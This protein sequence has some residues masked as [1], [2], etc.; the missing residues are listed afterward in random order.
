M[1][2]SGAPP[3]GEGGVSA[4]LVAF[5]LGTA[6]IVLCRLLLP[7]LL[8]NPNWAVWIS[9]L[10]AVAAI[11]TLGV[12][13]H[14][15]RR[16]GDI[17]R[18][19]DDLYY[20]GLLFTL[21]SLIYALVVLFLID[22]ADANLADRT[23]ELI[24]SFGIA[25]LSTVAGILGRI[26]LQGT[27]NGEQRSSGGESGFDARAPWSPAPRSP[28]A[29][30]RR[31]DLELARLA[32]RLRAELRGASDAFSHY[33]RMTL[34]Q[35]EDTKRHAQRVVEEFTRELRENARSAIVESESAYRKLGDQIHATGGELV[36]RVEQVTG[37]LAPL[38]ETV[39]SATHAAAGFPADIEQA[40]RSIEGLAD[41]AQ[42]VADRLDDGAESVARTGEA[43]ARNA[44]EQREIV[45][46]NLESARAMGTRMDSEASEWAKSEERIRIAFRVAG[47]MAGALGTLV[48]QVES[49]SR[50]LAE[51][52]GRLEAA[53]PSW[54]LGTGHRKPPCRPATAAC[55]GAQCFVMRS[56]DSW[57]APRCRGSLA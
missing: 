44:R 25:L 51:F 9:T 8:V 54:T 30:T 48:E 20:L 37:A 19:G 41:A 32:R 26:I 42:A 43:L 35:A 40:R 1:A 7:D 2:S 47:E 53:T 22:E 57:R 55:H 15:R 34:L 50:T 11:V 38:A 12:H 5:A 46:R 13:Y 49:A 31:E 29:P 16:A 4:F 14:L 36:G 18:S 39:G 52:S 23:Y 10:V 45:E 3:G 17:S 33:N 27:E 28:V 21:V 24:G 6:A 56:G